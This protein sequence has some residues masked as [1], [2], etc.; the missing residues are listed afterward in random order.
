M[1]SKIDKKN[2]FVSIFDPKTGFYIRSGIIDENGKDTGIDPFMCS[3]P[4][5]LDV[6][7]MGKCIHG[8]SGLCIKS[9]I[10]CYQNGLNIKKENMSFENFKKIIDQCKGKVFQVALGG[11][12]DP[13][14]HEE[15]E[16]L[17]KY[18][19]ENNIVPNYTTSGLGLTQNEVEITKQ[20]CG[21]VAVSEYRS[22]Y[23]R[24]AIKMFIDAGVKTNIHY[25]LGNN[26]IDEAIYKLE[27]NGFD[28]GINAVIFLL[29]KPIGL[30]SHKNVL[31]VNDE[32]IKR[33]FEIVDNNKFDFKIGFDSCS[34][35][36]IVNFTSK[37][38]RD[39][40]DFCE[41]SRYSAY[42]DSEMNMMPCSFGNQ[43]SKWYVNLNEY[44]IEEAWNSEIFEKFRNSLKNSC[45]NCKNKNN[46]GGGCPIVNEITLCNRKERC[47]YAC[48]E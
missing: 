19:R 8:E 2:R 25:V 33:F 3:F 30:G 27:N 34:C 14:K 23:T 40:I 43:D 22:E 17:V 37:I 45:P 16:Q 28:K 36:G 42:I 4:E 44:T 35:A 31:S 12:G 39:S 41:G 32:K 10:E 46:C 24:R 21:A 5:L 47:F 48:S 18:C 15:F 38:N 11:R 9:G 29:H 1:I 6:G 20:Y 7:V 13:N 26:T